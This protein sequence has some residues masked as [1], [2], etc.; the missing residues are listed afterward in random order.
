M[1]D[2][3]TTNTAPWVDTWV[4]WQK[5]ALEQWLTQGDSGGSQSFAAGL[6]AWQAAF[7]APADARGADLARRLFDVGRG[8]LLSL[9]QVA[10]ALGRTPAPGGDESRTAFR[11]AE[12][13]RQAQGLFS[14]PSGAPINELVD[15]WKRLSGSNAAIWQALATRGPATPGAVDPWSMLVCGLE[16]A[17]MGF[18]REYQE[19]L[20]ALARAVLDYQRRLDAMTAMLGRIHQAALELLIHRLEE[21]GREGQSVD[22]FRGIYDLWIECGEQAFQQTAHEDEYARLQAELTNAYAVL[23]MRQHTLSERMLA[24]LNLPNRAEMDTTHRRAKELRQRVDVLERAIAE[25]RE[26]VD[27]RQTTRRKVS[28]EGK[29]KR[30]R[31]ARRPGQEA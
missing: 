13:L 27:A 11:L 7:A 4:D 26:R 24:G 22:T 14:G 12:T 1:P 17:T 16:T 25:L 6:D 20:Q 18:S 15:V 30:S 23:R 29:R 3:K 10:A 8:Y 9:G 28:A 31:P 21:K 5:S 2:D 19:D